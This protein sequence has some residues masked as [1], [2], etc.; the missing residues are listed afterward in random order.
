MIFCRPSKY[1]LTI[2]VMH[3]THNQNPPNQK[4]LHNTNNNLK[5]L[6][7]PGG[8]V[9]KNLCAHGGDAR[10]VG[11][12]PG[13]RNFPWSRKWQ[14]TPI[15]LLGKFHGQR[16]LV[17]YSLGNRKK[18]H[19]IEHTCNLKYIHIYTHNFIYLQNC[20]WGNSI[21]CASEGIFLLNCCSSYFCLQNLAQ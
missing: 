15:F 4:Y 16:R 5:Y 10:E 6:G 14:P 18:L 20:A 3:K 13:L 9:V 19:M 2:I 1:F 7:F 8:T 12:I 17:G 11:S 21:C